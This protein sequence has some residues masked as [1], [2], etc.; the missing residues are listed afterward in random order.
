MPTEVI[1]ALLD[2]ALTHPL[3]AL[4]VCAGAAILAGVQLRRL[5]IDSVP[6]PGIPAWRWLAAG[7]P[8]NDA[9]RLGRG[10]PG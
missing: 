2:S 4:C 10:D 9:E 7:A 3:L 6:L 1:S 8:S 5:G